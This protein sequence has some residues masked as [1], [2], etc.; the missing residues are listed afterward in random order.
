MTEKNNGIVIHEYKIPV[1]GI[2]KKVI[3]HFSDVH[4]TEFDDLSNESETVRAKDATVSWANGRLGFAK[5]N[6][7]NV[8]EE[9]KM[10]SGVHFTNLLKTASSGDAFVMTGDICD[11]IN[12]ANMRKLDAELKNIS[13]PYVAVCGNH[14]KACDIPDGFIYSALKEPVQICDLGDLLIVGIDDSDRNIT[15]SQNE[16]LKK[17]LNKNKPLII[18]FHVPI[19]TEGNK[20]RLINC[21]EY[22]RLNHENASEETLEF[23]EIIKKNSDRIIAVLAGHLHFANNTE[24]TDGLMQYV[25]TQ[26]ILGNINK[27]EIGE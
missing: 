13:V 25:S 8:S 3:Y 26:G 6:N 7:E 14:D 2:K 22:F 18:V 9:Q 11:F 12:G 21:G 19:M 4:L 1:K 24:I 15:A 20:E 27:Y 23:I 17:L 16:Q 5:S 10:P